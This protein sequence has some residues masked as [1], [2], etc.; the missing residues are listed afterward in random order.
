MTA[1]PIQLIAA[2]LFAVAIL[3]TFSTK[4]FE[5]L[6]HTRPAHAGL[7]HLLGEVEAGA[8]QLVQC[9]DDL[10]R[11]VEDRRAQ[12][13]GLDGAHHEEDALLGGQ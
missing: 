7:W 10:E 13:A 8:A 4:L 6:A 12:V 5:H 11:V 9:G 1:T 3:H 2:A